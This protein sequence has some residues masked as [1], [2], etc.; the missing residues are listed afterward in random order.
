MKINLTQS[1]DKMIQKLRKTH[2]SRIARKEQG[3]KKNT[4]EKKRNMRGAKLSCLDQN[5]TVS[6][7]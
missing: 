6:Y 1:N 3:E 2:I 5:V 4:E 7:E